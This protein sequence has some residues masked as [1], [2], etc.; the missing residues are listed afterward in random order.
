M[1]NTR[2]S[3]TSELDGKQ[4]DMCGQCNKLVK[5]THKSLLCELCCRWFHASCQ[6]VSD[7]IYGIIKK[8]SNSKGASSQLHWYCNSSCNLLAANFIGNITKMQRDIGELTDNVKNL[9]NRMNMIEDGEFT[10]HMIDKIQNI[11]QKTQEDT[12]IGNLDAE[13]VERLVDEKARE[14]IAES[15]DKAR[16]KNNR[17]IFKLQES[18]STEV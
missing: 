16:R 13:N 3:S 4:E 8:D 10:Q 2:S 6:G 12:P 18:T 14:H 7:D 1:A 17:V 5:K 15:E 9:D 11:Q